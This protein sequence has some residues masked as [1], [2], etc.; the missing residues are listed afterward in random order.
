MT[1]I[2]R[3]KSCGAIVLKKIENK[4]RVL[5]IR[6]KQGHW[7]FPKGHVEP[8][9]SEH[10][11]AAREVREE[12]GI[13]IAFLDGFRERTHYSPAENVEKEVVYFLA[14]QTGGMPKVQE[15]EVSEMRWVSL[16]DAGTLM[17]Y[18]NDTELLRKAVAKIRMLESDED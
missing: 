5:L 10:E 1:E 2:K 7:C 3:E 16:V 15:E 13:E 17:T 6:Q 11:T 8:E 14:Y 12:T 4:L 18:D 9:E